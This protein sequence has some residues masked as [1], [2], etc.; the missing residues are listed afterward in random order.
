MIR[1]LLGSCDYSIQVWFN[2]F[3]AESFWSSA[4]MSPVILAA[5]WHRPMLS[6]SE[7]LQ[8]M[9]AIL[10][11]S[12]G[13][14]VWWASLICGS[15][16]LS[17]IWDNSNSSIVCPIR[18]SMYAGEAAPAWWILTG[19]PETRLKSRE[20]GTVLCIEF[21]CLSCPWGWI[22]ATILD[23]WEVF[24]AW[25]NCAFRELVIGPADM[26]RYRHLLSLSGHIQRG[27]W[28]VLCACVI[29]VEGSSRSMRPS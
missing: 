28:G 9:S 18:D 1:V 22:S 4:L 14:R 19:A 26:G 25:V 24:P 12:L 2:C 13:W 17:S 16:E 27:C 21:P 5:V 23:S 29:G 3:Y 11:G 10:V 20:S 6:M 15:V 8:N 7:N